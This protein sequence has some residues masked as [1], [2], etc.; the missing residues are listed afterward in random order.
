MLSLIQ[1]NYINLNKFSVVSYC[2]RS[3]YIE[4]FKFFLHDINQYLNEND[5]NYI[6]KQLKNELFLE[7]LANIE[8]FKQIYYLFDKNKNLF[9]LIVDERNRNLIQISIII[10]L[11][12]QNL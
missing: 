8:C 3:E 6:F 11:I 7:S 9:E 10:I 5:K 2:L 12:H 4:L 1:P